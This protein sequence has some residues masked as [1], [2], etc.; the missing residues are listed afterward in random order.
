MTGTQI[1]KDGG[2]GVCLCI[3]KTYHNGAG[4]TSRWVGIGVY[5]IVNKGH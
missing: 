2:G 3:M 1:I 5:R 4:K